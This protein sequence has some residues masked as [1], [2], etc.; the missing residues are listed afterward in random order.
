MKKIKL[1]LDTSVL[2]FVLTDQPML[3]NRK[4]STINLLEEIKAGNYDAYISEQVLVEINKAEETKTKDLMDL[5][6][7]L[8]LESLPLSEDIEELAD[9]YV[10][11]EI[12]PL[13]YRDDA[14]H[15]AIASANNLDVIVSWNFNHMV[16]LKTKQG[17]IAVNSLLG[18]KSIEIIT[19]E[20]V[21]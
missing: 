8:P 15:I 12:I 14:L 7:A 10:E 9:K 19:P 4:E 2:N 21:V 1:Y 3:A 13:K 16:K 11:E 5:I 17:V 6:G 20:E 18:Y